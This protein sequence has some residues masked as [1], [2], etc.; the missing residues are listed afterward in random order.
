MNKIRKICIKVLIIVLLW[1]NAD[2]KP[3][4]TNHGTNPDDEHMGV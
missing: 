3:V 4:I 2:V 1:L